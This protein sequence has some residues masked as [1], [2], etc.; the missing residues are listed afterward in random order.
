MNKII[1][2]TSIDFQRYFFVIAAILLVLLTS[3]TVKG[4]IKTLVGIPIKMERNA[5]KGG[6]N[7]TVN[8]V[9][10]CA[11][12]EVATIQIV[13]K[14]ASS[15]NDLLPLVLFTAGILF[16]F[17]FLRVVKEKKHPLYKGSGEIRN[18]IPIFLEYRKLII[19]FSS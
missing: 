11:E 19:P 13:Q 5:T 8:E 12:L 18:T 1:P 15:A 6:H 3:C 7:L 4:G 2:N 9:D 16:L 17:S 14:I 10:A